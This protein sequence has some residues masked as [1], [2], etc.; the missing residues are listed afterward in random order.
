MDDRW[1]N[2]VKEYGAINITGFR[3][4]DS[5]RNVVRQFLR[6][7]EKLDPAHWPGAGRPYIQVGLQILVYSSLGHQVLNFN[8]DQKS[9]K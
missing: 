6:G 3:I 2:K 4:V 9:I 1:D 5:N 7:W 8:S